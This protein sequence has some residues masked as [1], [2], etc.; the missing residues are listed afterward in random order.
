M[1]NGLGNAIDLR[2]ARTDAS[3]RCTLSNTELAKLITKSLEHV[4]AYALVLL[5]EAAY[6]TLSKLDLYDA[7]LHEPTH[8]KIAPSVA[9]G[10]SGRCPGFKAI[11][12]RESLQEVQR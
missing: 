11:L 12:P 10:P 6:P 8:V 1:G 5:A 2:K 3:V 9:L 7:V 4:P